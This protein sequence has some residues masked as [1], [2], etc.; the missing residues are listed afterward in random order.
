[1]AT[2]SSHILDSISGRSAGGIKVELFR[3]QPTTGRERVFEAV[4]DEDGRVSET[5]EADGTGVQYELVFHGADYFAGREP[6]GA[7]PPTVQAV[8]VVV[9]RMSMPDPDARYHIPLVLAPHSYTVWWS[10]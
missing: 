3:L 1:M 4:A 9:V 10:G 5:V 8:D 2:V 6:P 7:V